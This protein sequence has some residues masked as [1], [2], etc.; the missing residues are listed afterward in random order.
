MAMPSSGA[1]G[2]K[3]CTAQACSSICVAN[4]YVGTASLSSMGVAAGKTAPHC[5]REFYGYSAKIDVNFVQYGSS[6][7]TNGVST[8]VYRNYCL[9]PTP[10]AGQTYLLCITP[11]IR[12]IGQSSGSYGQ[13]CITCNLTQIYCCRVTSPTSAC[14][15]SPGALR[16][17]D[18]TDCIRVYVCACATNTSCVGNIC[19]G[20]CIFSISGTYHQKGSTCPY[21]RVCS[22]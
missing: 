13:V 7:G 21:A 9:T 18:S 22:G 6:F 14:I 19:V 8:Y 17:I 3:F 10:A 11:N 4:G 2:L 16:T 5:M 12:N 20:A 15:T 1:I